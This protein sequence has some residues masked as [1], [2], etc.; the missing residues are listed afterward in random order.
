MRKYISYFLY[1]LKHKWYAEN[2][3]KIKLH[4][5]TRE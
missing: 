1:V 2:K 4:P 3:E 5:N